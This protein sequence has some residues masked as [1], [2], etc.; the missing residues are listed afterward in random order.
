M[1][2]GLAFINQYLANAP[3]VRDY[4]VSLCPALDNV[5]A[6]NESTT[7]PTGESTHAQ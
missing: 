3:H 5:E 6:R 2:S 1:T 7:S 4:F